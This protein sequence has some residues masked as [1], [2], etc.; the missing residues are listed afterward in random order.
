MTGKYMHPCRLALSP[1]R[2][3]ARATVTPNGASRPSR[4]TVA[5]I[6][7]SRP[8]RGALALIGAAF[9]LATFAAP[10]LAGGGAIHLGFGDCAGAGSST[11]S[12]TNAC[13][14]N[15]GGVPIVASFNAPASM[16]R[17]T[18]LEA[19]LTFYTSGMSLSPWW[20]MESQPAGACRSGRIS[21]GFDF[22]GG[23][24]TCA[25]FWGG[26]AMGGMEYLPNGLGS[27]T[28]TADIGLVCA[29]AEPGPV[30]GSSEYYAFSV[31]ISK[32]L[33]TGPGS[34]AGCTDKA[35][36]VLDYIKLQQPAEMR[37][38]YT[39][40]QGDQSAILYNGGTADAGCAAARAQKSS[41]GAIKAIYH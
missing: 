2:I 10:S 37:A 26:R 16:P 34:C 4:A 24:Y 35:C 27:G 17:L 21:V 32:A 40:T 19:G 33:S 15:T 13:A 22:T 8:S 25:D 18:S 30:D 1:D 7:A 6:G 39:M 9:L 11:V 12:F 36:F 31:L 41:W 20:H 14:T 28:N 38:D 29:I 5:L 23:P 3:L